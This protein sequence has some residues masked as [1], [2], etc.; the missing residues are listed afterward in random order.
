MQARNEIVRVAIA[1][2]VNVAVLE[3]KVRAMIEERVVAAQKSERTSFG[4]GETVALRSDP[5]R[6][7]VVTSM[8]PSNR[9]TRYGVF[10]DGR[11]ETLY[12]Q[13]AHSRRYRS[14]RPLAQPATS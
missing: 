5:R 1:N 13:P 9:E 11:M 4:V 10:I 12:A 14:F 3:K 8:T 2:G 7:G 6:V